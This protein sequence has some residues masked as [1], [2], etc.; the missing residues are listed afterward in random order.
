MKPT[1]RQ[2]PRLIP[3]L[4]TRSTVTANKYCST[5]D[6]FIGIG[7]ECNTTNLTSGAHIIELTVN[8][9]SGQTGTDNVTLTVIAP[10]LAVSNI[11]FSNPQPIEGEAVTIS[12]IVQNASGNISANVSAEI[13]KPDSGTDNIT[14]AEGIVGYY[15]GTFT[16]T[17]LSGRYNVTIYA[18]RTGFVGDKD[19]L[20]FEILDTTP[21]ASVTN[22]TVFHSN[23][24]LWD[25][26]ARRYKRS[27]RVPG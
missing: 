11:S 26:V 19:S 3:Q 23:S 8:D 16:N 7:C 27:A 18:N 4:I 12:C 10:D 9:S 15:Y 14:M 1:T 25:C 24:S 13:A 6:G 22:I 20:S 2:Q 5:L 21:P 17:S